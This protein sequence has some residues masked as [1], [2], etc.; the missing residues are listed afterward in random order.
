MTTNAHKLKSVAA[1]KIP[2]PPQLSSEG[3]QSSACEQVNPYATKD[4]WPR[5]DCATKPR[6]PGTCTPDTYGWWKAGVL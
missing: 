5:R 3:Y 6:W 2:P 1:S 4:K